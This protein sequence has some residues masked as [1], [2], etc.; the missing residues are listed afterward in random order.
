[1][2]YLYRGDTSNNNKRE[3]R[4]FVMLNTI[5][6]KWLSVAALWACLQRLIYLIFDR[7]FCTVSTSWFCWRSTNGND[8]RLALRTAWSWNR[9]I[10]A[11]LR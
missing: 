11:T 4:N 3:K 7:R 5:D 10:F 6:R 9:E 1:V 2:N 8:W